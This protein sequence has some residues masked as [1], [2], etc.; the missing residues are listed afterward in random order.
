MH[1]YLGRGDTAAGL[2]D[3]IIVE[4]EVPYHREMIVGGKECWYAEEEERRRTKKDGCGK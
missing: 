2:V 3:C 1:G 4:V